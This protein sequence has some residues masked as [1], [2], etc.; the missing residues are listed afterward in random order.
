MYRWPYSICRVLKRVVCVC[1]YRK[2]G[3]TQY[4]LT[5]AYGFSR[6][7]RIIGTTGKQSQTQTAVARASNKPKKWLLMTTVHVCIHWPFPTHPVFSGPRRVEHARSIP[8]DR[9]N[10][11]KRLARLRKRS[12]AYVYIY[13]MHTVGYPKI[14][15]SAT[16]G[17]RNLD[18]SPSN[19]AVCNM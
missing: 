8:S 1:R 17:N 4:R 10:K 18:A 11:Q 5:R 14:R 19:V 9:V 13:I 6:F 12:D 15:C 2:H 3:F 7:T 16:I